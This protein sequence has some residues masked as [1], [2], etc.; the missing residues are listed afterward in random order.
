MSPDLDRLIKLQ[1]LDTT[2][3][4]ARRT[5]AAHPQR[6]ADAEARLNDAKQRVDTAKQ[7][8]KD[9]QDARR[10]LE[11]DVALY[12]GRLSK[13]KDQQAAVK[14]N[15]EYQALGHE[16]ETAQH[17]LGGVE[18]KILER[19]V[20]ADAIAADVKQ[21]ETALTAQQKEIEAEKKTLNDELASVQSS[22]QQATE[23]RG[24]LVREMEP[25]LMALYDQVAKA[26]KGVA[27]T[28]ATRDGLCAACH[29]RLRPHV[30]QQIRQND[31]IIQCDSCHRI[32]YYVPPPPPVE[33]AVVHRS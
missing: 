1:H 2:I 7:R 31:S 27:I 18:E 23:S 28:T 19:M 32:L 17:D 16:I 6:L 25:R 21:A 26:R 22:L 8:L 4:N 30:F 11:K 14:T 5:I 20:E 13:F 10:A 3:E 33:H 29:V 12:Q 9:N 15:K 24:T